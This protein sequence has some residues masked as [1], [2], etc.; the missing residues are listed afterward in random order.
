MQLSLPFRRKPSDAEDVT[1]A[2][3][4]EAV[5]RTSA[6]TARRTH[7][8]SKREL[9]QAT[10]KRRPGGRPVQPAPT[11]RREAA[12]RMREQQRQARAE[13]RAGMMAGDDKY[14]TSRDKG[15]ERRLVREVV[16]ARRNLASYLLLVLFVVMFATYT[17]PNPAML[18]YANM[19]LYVAFA[20]V[21]IDSVLLTRRV[22]KI[23]EKR[24]PKATKPVRSYYFYAIMR[25][26]QFRRMRMPAPLV[27]IGDRV[28]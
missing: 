7:T 13:Q 15:P 16:D 12:K 14:L 9:G 2:T 3:E 21:L 17:M 28:E 27:K 26:L 23:I 10:P 18:L 11:N 20:A 6:A 4:E 19:L 22:K 5:T 1:Q 24:F 25:A 8:A